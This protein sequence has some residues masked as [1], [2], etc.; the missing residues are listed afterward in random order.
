[1][2]YGKSIDVNSGLNYAGDG[3]YQGAQNSYDVKSERGRSGFDFRHVF[4]MNFIYRLPFNRN[5]LLRDWQ[6]AGS[7]TAYSGQPYTP[8]LSG[9]SQDL[10]QATRPDRT[11]NGS[12]P[13]PSPTLWFDLTAF[14]IVPDTAFRFGNSGR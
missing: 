6:L 10:A 13:N 7:G 5:F 4:S 14:P 8:Q 3:G 2:T 11:V 9:P 12:L 1:Y